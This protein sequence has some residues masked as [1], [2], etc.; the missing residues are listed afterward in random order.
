MTVTNFAGQFMTVSLNKS[1]HGYVLI[2]GK[3][4]SEE[5][6]CVET[7]DRVFDKWFDVIT[8]DETVAHSILTPKLISGLKKLGKR[9]SVQFAGDTAVVACNNDKN[10][11]ETKRQVKDKSDIELCRQEFRKELSD[12]L[13]ILDIMIDGCQNNL[14]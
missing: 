9:T 12:V 3:R 4:G 13:A 7:G 5:E 10:L 14:S 6:N 11:F 1:V 8:S 2:K